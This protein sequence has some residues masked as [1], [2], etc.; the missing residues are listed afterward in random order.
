MVIADAGYVADFEAA[1]AAAD[2][3]AAYVEVVADAAAAESSKTSLVAEA[4]ISTVAGDG[5]YF[6]RHLRLRR[7]HHRLFLA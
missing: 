1:A 7:H 3:V 5:D 2:N 6:Q 4:E